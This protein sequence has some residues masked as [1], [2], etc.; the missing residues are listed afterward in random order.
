MTKSTGPIHD[1]VSDHLLDLLRDAG[2]GSSDFV[3]V[4]LDT[5]GIGGHFGGVDGRVTL[6]EIMR[7]LVVLTGSEEAAVEWL[8]NSRGY[9]KAVGDDAYLALENGDFWSLTVMEDWL[10]ILLKHRL[11]CPVLIDA[12]FGQS[13]A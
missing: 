7:T 9:T 10:K 5:P 13:T 3:D 11:D 6:I 8:F 4:I 1:G 12:I 2:S